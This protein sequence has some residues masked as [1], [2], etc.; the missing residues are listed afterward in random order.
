MSDINLI[1]K[2]TDNASAVLNRINKNV[3]RLDK[4]GRRASKSMG[5]MGAALKGVAVAAAAIGLG[6][7][8]SGTVQTIAKFESLRA[9]LKTVTGSVDGARVAFARIQE[10]TAKTPFQ[11]DEV[12][13]SFIILQ[14][15]GIDTSIKSLN[16]FGNIAAANGKSFNQLAEAVGDALT[17]EFERLKEFG[18]KVQR[19]NDKFVM[20]MGET[21]LAVTDSAGELVN[22]L[23][24]LG[25]E[26][27]R[28]A[29]GL[30]DQSAT[31]GG[32]FSNLKDNISQFAASIGEG[33]LNSAMK[34]VL[35][36][37]NSLGGEAPKVGRVIGAGLGAAIKVTMKRFKDLTTL[38]KAAFDAMSGFVMQEGGIVD[39]VT[40]AFDGIRNSVKYYLKKIL[41]F[42]G[43]TFQ[44]IP[45]MLKKSVNFMISSYQYF[46]EQ[47][48]RIIKNL[49]EIFKQVFIG[50]GNL[51]VD[52]GTR[53]VTQFK[54]LGGALKEAIK[55]GFN[56]FDDRGFVET[57]N[58]QMS[59]A[60]AGF[61]IADSFNMPKAVLLDQDDVNRIY[62]TDYFQLAK[63]I[64]L[65]ASD[66]VQ[67]ALSGLGIT[68]NGLQPGKGAI[69]FLEEYNRLL[70]E[71]EA[72][73]KALE[74][75]LKNQT[76]AQ[77]DNTNTKKKGNKELTDEEKFL[78]KVTKSYDDLIL[79]VT[80]KS[81]AD[82]INAELIERTHAAYEAGT[83]T[84]AQYSEALT[85]LDSK[86]DTLELRALR[87]AQT[88]K[89]GFES[90]AG[91][92][93]DVFFNMFT[94]VTS[95]F[96]GLKSIARMVFEMVAKAII[97]AFIVKPIIGA[98]TGGMGIPFFANGGMIPSGQAAIVGERGPEIITGANGGTRVF[99]NTESR[100]SMNS[101]GSDDSPLT[102]NFN[103]TAVDTQSGVQ[104]L[105]ENKS[106]ITGM[107]Q[108][109]YNQRGVRGPLG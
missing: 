4:N 27:G 68:I 109:A 41:E 87:T 99:S 7:L 62:G 101:G 49:P 77:N 44:D 65:G 96:E 51:T 40:S 106:T 86:H 107:I 26:G 105:M 70:A 55:A 19:E 57:L 78:K 21:Q 1:I 39:T 6:K 103:L 89:Q 84:L 64:I 91:R 79:K 63:N 52:F 50:I 80:K 53:L 34:D 67:D 2:A 82:L 104:F 59:N 3:D 8:I 45:N 71:G 85:D 11:L 56:L 47:T 14:R 66:E 108:T 74:E 48:F 42:F 22:E 35:D 88:I 76:T 94:G 90:M 37:F 12:T 54:S 16:A 93:T 20:S 31:L 97:Q 36:S 60:F 23:K 9:S 92:V 29:S 73:Q 58:E 30:A 38:A 83:L 81:E 15:Y 75:A 17:G 72:E 25:E 100:N 18:I 46:V 13:E 43:L 69:G 98:L 102:V 32:K 5:G 61:S 28:Y 24:K 33:G 95:A 10:F